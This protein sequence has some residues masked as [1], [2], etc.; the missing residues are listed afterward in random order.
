M[1]DQEEKKLTAQDVLT[2]FRRKEILDAVDRVSKSA[3]F[4]HLTMDKVA[5][6]AGIAK[7][8]IYKYFSDKDDLLHALFA[9]SF[10]GL[11]LEASRVSEK[12]GMV[13]DLILEF[14]NTLENFSDANRDLIIQLHK[15]NYKEKHEARETEIMTCFMLSFE[16]ILRTGIARGE[17]REIDTKKLSLLFFGMLHHAFFADMHMAGCMEKIPLGFVIDVFL[18]GIKKTN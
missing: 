13:K 10:D 17:L 4:E 3:G 5:E 1:N 18:N 16:N 8:T 9:Q 7:G 6:E 12:E 11:I 14:A 15:A 2:E